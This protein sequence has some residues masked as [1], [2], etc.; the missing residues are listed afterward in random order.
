MAKKMAPNRASG[1]FPTVGTSVARSVSARPALR[2][3]AVPKT[4]NSKGGFAEAATAK[5]RANI[6]ERLGAKLRPTAVLYAVNAAAA[7]DTYRN[8]RYVPSA[9]G[10]RDFW[11]KR[12]YGQ[13]QQ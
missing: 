4:G 12:A 2:G 1:D 8:V 11:N 10:N 13:N 7:N 6:Q 9:I 5:H 3:T